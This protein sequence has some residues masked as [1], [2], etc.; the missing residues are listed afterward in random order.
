[1]APSGCPPSL[2]LC[3]CLFLA[4]GFAQAG[5][6]LVVPMDGSH[7]FT[8]QM[9]VEKLSHRGHEVVVVI[10]EVSWH[11]GVLLNIRPTQAAEHRV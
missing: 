6:L 7:W 8:M 3:V 5:R 10:P 1:M 2:P 4:S 11:M 9:I